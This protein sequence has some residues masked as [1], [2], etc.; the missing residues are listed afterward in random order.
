MRDGALE[1]SRET[2]FSG[3]NGGMENHFSCSADHL[4]HW[5]LHPIDPYSAE[6]DDHT[7]ILR[8]HN[9]L[10]KSL[11]IRRDSATVH[12]STGVDLSILTQGVQVYITLCIRPCAP[13]SV[14]LS[15]Y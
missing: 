5:Q 3:A 4:Q 13:L 12:R 6:R 9:M 15:S 8:A 7:H 10:V 2:K 1:P 14:S 11:A